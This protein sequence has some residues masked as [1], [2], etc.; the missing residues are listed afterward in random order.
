MS[1]GIYRILNILNK[2]C[3]IGSSQNIEKRWYEHK[4]T[5]KNKKHHSILLQRAYNKYGSDSF[6]YEII[7]I[8]SKEILIQ[9]E[10]FYFDTLNPEYIILKKA[11]SFI[12]YKHTSLYEKRYRIINE[13][14][15][16][17][18][19]KVKNKK[20]N[21]CSDETKEKISNAHKGRKFSLEHKEKISNAHKGKKLTDEHKKNIKKNLTYERMYDMQK[22][23]VISRKLNGK[24][25]SDKRK[26]Q[27]SKMNSIEVVGIDDFGKNLYYFK[28]YKEASVFIEK[29]EVTLY[30]AIKSGKKFKGCIWKRKSKEL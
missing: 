12:G 2:K 10:Q 30:R 26:K 27:I 28:S 7:E 11:S 1:S 25:M 4:R 9:R 17:I 3:Y 19:L 18:R 22:K 21:K 13:T 16:K 5:L 20:R 23:S 15:E 14:K 29:S 24:K 8:C 6:I